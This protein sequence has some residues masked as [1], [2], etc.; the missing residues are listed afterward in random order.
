MKSHTRL[1]SFRTRAW[2]A[3]LLGICGAAFAAAAHAAGAPLLLQG[4]RFEV[5]AAWRTSNGQTGVG[6]PTRLTEES[7]TFW[8]FSPTNI[9]MVVKVLDACTGPSGRFWVF[10]GGLTDVEVDLTVT[11]TATAEKKTYR[12][13]QGTPFEPIQDTGAFNT[14]SAPPRCGQG[15]LF[16][17][18]A[19]PR[20]DPELENL[21]LFMSDGVTAPQSVY[22]RVV[23]DV[24]ALRV[25][26]PPFVVN[27]APPYD[28]RALI[29]TLTPEAALAVRA[30]TYHAWDCLNSWYRV[31]RVDPLSD[32][33][34]VLRF[35]GLLDIPRIAGDYAV[36][37]GIVRTDTN[38]YASLA[39]PLPE[40]GALCGWAEGD[41]FYYF[42]RYPSP[43]RYYSSELGQPPVARGPVSAH[44]F[45][46]ALA[47]MCY[48]EHTMGRS[49]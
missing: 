10:A 18:A 9:E 40:A 41:T 23:A 11:D 20:V 21:A 34:V 1:E 48:Q 49:L 13:P 24:A 44:S 26:E 19:T 2:R 7:G 6:T 27:Y 39:T 32:Q 43:T 31:D 35:R 17:L 46:Q 37:P 29:V 12:N 4:G 33:S 16:E 45:V 42:L 30:G 22:D 5:Q 38:D 8:F 47:S 28:P 14:C 36:L 15:S 25:E 3:A